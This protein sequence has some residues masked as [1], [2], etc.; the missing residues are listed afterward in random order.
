MSLIQSQDLRVATGRG[1]LFARRWAPGSTAAAR[2][3]PVVLFHDSLGSVELWRD[4]PERLAQA[5]GRQIVAYDRLGFGR[6]DAFPGTLPASFIRDEAIGSFRALRE[7]LGLETFV[8]LGH[9]V[10]GCMAVATAAHYPDHCQGLITE[11]AQAF[12]EPRTLEGIRQARRAF[13]EPGQLERLQRYHG[14]K[15]AWV[16]SA[17]IETWLSTAFADWRLDED[18]RRV[19]CPT[20]ALHGDRD[21]YGSVIHPQRIAEGVAGPAT[22]Q[23]FAACG[24]VP[25]REMA[26]PVL[27]AIVD[28]Q[29]A[30]ATAIG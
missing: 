15:A 23:V 11:S 2:S 29:K 6:S 22:R 7:Q 3:S 17:W 16:L 20:L 5:T 19:Q 26:E 8:A 27:A 25:H 13:A 14:D 1:H 9:S 18:L 30:H 12:V 4:F 28:W 10:G 21:E 24:H